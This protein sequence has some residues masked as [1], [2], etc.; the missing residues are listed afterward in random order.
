MQDVEGFSMMLMRGLW[1]HWVFNGG[2]TVNEKQYKRLVEELSDHYDAKLTQPP[3]AVDDHNHCTTEAPSWYK[4]LDVKHRAQLLQGITAE[5]LLNDKLW[6]NQAKVIQART[7]RKV[8]ASGEL[9]TDS[10][11]R[12]FRLFLQGS[13]EVEDNDLEE[14]AWTRNT[15]GA[16]NPTDR[17]LMSPC[18]IVEENLWILRMMLEA[19]TPAS[20]D[21]EVSM[22]DQNLD[23]HA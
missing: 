12:N 15:S 19:K 3:P 17:Q 20:F 8:E 9:L 2:T 6:A 10:D 1:A 21:D 23:K 18:R 5:V 4:D 13:Q 7:I 11:I 22:E 16:L 14:K